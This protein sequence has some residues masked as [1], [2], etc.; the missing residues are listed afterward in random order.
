MPTHPDLLEQIGHT[1]PQ[2]TN[3]KIQRVAHLV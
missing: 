3:D 2:K 1:F